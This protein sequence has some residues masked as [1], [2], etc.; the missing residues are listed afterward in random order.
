MCEHM[1]LFGGET[2]QKK[3]G[4]RKMTYGYMGKILWISLADLRVSTLDTMDYAEKYIGGRGIAT[5]I[6]WEK[7][8]PQ[9]RDGFDPDNLL[10]LMTGPLSGTLSPSS[11]RTAAFFKSVLQWPKSWF[12]YSNFGG[13]WGPQLKFAGYDGVVLHGKSDHPIYLWIN[14]EKVE[15][16]DAREL[17]GK[18]TYY[19]QQV[20]V[21]ELGGDEKIKVLTIGPAGENLVRQAILLTDTGDAAGCGGAGAVMGSKNVK[22]IAVKGIKGVKVADPKK[23][24]IESRR[25]LDL[26]YSEKKRKPPG[27]SSIDVPDAGISIGIKG[28]PL[29]YAFKRN[30]GCFACPVMCHNFLTP[31][32]TPAGEIWC[33]PIIDTAEWASL[34]DGKKTAES[35]AFGDTVYIGVPT[36]DDKAWLFGKTLDLMGIN[37]F[38]VGGLGHA[39]DGS[40][41]ITC[42]RSGIFT[43]TI[44]SPI[45]LH[46]VGTREFTESFA[47]AIAQRKGK[48]ATLLGEGVV[49]AAA[50]LK[51]HPWEFG[52][53]EEQAERQWEVCERAYPAHGMINHHFY[54]K[55]IATP[56]AYQTPICAVLWALASRDP[57]GS[58]H[59]AYTVYDTGRHGNSKGHAKAAFFDENAGCRYLDAEGCPILANQKGQ[60][61]IGKWYDRH[62]VER[63][64]AKA[65]FTKGTPQAVKFTLAYGIQNDSLPL[66]DHLFPFIA[67]RFTPWESPPSIASDPKESTDIAMAS[68]LYTAVTG[69]SKSFEQLMDDSWRIWLLE[70]AIH[71]RD[72]DRTRTDDTFNKYYFDRPDAQG[73]SIDRD[74]F[75]K[76]LDMV[77][78]LMGCDVKTGNPTR[79]TLERY[80][81]KDV[82]DELAKRG[83]LPQKP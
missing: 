67:C 29:E 57:F 37:A 26:V 38:D 23:L 52:L 14:D 27:P 71:I 21:K 20:I 83:K 24:I 49:R 45:E 53:T 56:G 77:Y 41:L 10:I 19:T 60:P 7:A 25:H 5:R 32:N 59:F 72:N 33:A 39:G 30:S 79:A 11:G 68:R 43:D 34:V 65:N 61:E 63:K 74:E 35:N 13:E 16:R 1:L 6:F 55:W 22:A 73:I 48:F 58:H 3:R 69:I 78:E 64:P 46:K 28:S 15:F 2:C 82:A 12:S 44:T 42:Y 50:Y 4:L 47:T 66:C 9:M 75:E 80:E 40:W 8:K 17:W 62:N 54:E 36:Y 76:G 51:E 31:S 70:R 81:L 18:D